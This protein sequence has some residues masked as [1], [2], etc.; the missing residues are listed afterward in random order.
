MCL[1]DSHSATCCSVFPQ[2][3]G[4]LPSGS[5]A[6]PPGSWGGWWGVAEGSSPESPKEPREAAGLRGGAILTSYHASFCFGTVC[7]SDPQWP[8]ERV[9]FEAASV[10]WFEPRSADALHLWHVDAHSH[11]MTGTQSLLAPPL[12]VLK[13]RSCCVSRASG[14]FTTLKVHI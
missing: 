11:R 12:L 9:T 14:S 3:P 4:L 13:W 8:S 6:G 7:G 10:S 2:T 5:A 1:C